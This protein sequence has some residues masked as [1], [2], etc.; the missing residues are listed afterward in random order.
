MAMTLKK[1]RE[2]TSIIL[3]V[4]FTVII[5]LNIA[6][7]LH[8]RTILPKWD[9]VPPVPTQTSASFSALGDNG[10]AY[11]MLGYTLQNLGNTGGR[12]MALKDYNYEALE[13][14]FF[15]T[16]ALDRQA[17]FVPFIASYYFGAVEDEP[18]KTAHVV[19]FLAEAGKE[20]YPQKW[21]WLAQAVYL[22][23]FQEKDLHKA[24]ILA[25]RLAAMPGNLPPWARQMPAFVNMAIG[26]R[27][28]SYDLMVR[29]LIT[30]KDNLDPNEVNA[31]L[32]FICD[33]T[34]TPDEAAKNQL[35]QNRQ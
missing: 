30:E 9:N 22:A 35:C 29:M 16:H 12:Y 11:R 18:E 27:Q 23:R 1:G 26:D 13:R 4:W 33:R 5:A 21:R 32:D 17:N 14:W 25:N 7:W 15:V 31:M 8:S 24:L 28:A 19:N 3:Y 34:L 20:P 6:F 10:M 2:R